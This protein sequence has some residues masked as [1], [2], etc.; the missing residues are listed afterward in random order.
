MWKCLTNDTHWVAMNIVELVF[1]PSWSSLLSWFLNAMTKC[2][3]SQQWKIDLSIISLHY[4]LQTGSLSGVS[5]YSWKDWSFIKWPG[6]RNLWWCCLYILHYQSPRYQKVENCYC[7]L[8]QCPIHF[9]W[10]WHYLWRVQIHTVSN[11]FRSN[12]AIW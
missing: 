10:I 11:K 3:H 4:I 12:T 1:I 6:A 9:S 7:I 8:D 5:E 2:N